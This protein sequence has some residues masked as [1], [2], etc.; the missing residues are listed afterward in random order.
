NAIKVKA[1]DLPIY[2]TYFG[3]VKFNQS[4]TVHAERNGVAS[5][6]RIKAGQSVKAGQTLLSYP[7]Q[8]DN[9]AIENKQI[10]QAQISLTELKANHQRQKNLFEK[11]AV[12]RVSVEALATQIKVMENTIE[13][14]RMGVEKIHVVKAPLS[15]MVTE[16]H[17]E[18]GQQIAMGMPLFTIAQSNKTE[19]EFFVLPKDVAA[20]VVGKPI[21]MIDGR[22]V[23]EGKI[24]EKATQIDPTRK[25][26]KVRATF[27]QSIQQLLVGS[28]V[29]LRFLK[30]TLKA[31]LVIPEATLIQQGKDHY[32]YTAKAGKAIKQKIKIAQRIDLEVVVQQGLQE[33]VELITVGM[34]KLKNNT[35][36]EIIP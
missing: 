11:G 31:I 8:D 32:V 20:I 12:N 35:A 22:K 26:V 33:G 30:E 2:D 13:Q 16:V 5:N 29:E 14:L 7:R 28:T 9:I 21:E 10:E 17:V 24:S 6:L 34:N 1:R 3:E 18:K 15:G 36:I 25:A 27:D 23:I 19:V 4:I